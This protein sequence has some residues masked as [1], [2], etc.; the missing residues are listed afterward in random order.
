M[1]GMLLIKFAGMA[2]FD[3]VGAAWADFNNLPW[4]GLLGRCFCNSIASAV[5]TDGPSRRVDMS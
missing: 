2:M 1:G 5:G 3:S 4:A